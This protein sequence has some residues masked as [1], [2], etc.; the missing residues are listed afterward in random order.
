M[1]EPA[2]EGGKIVTARKGTARFQIHVKGQPAHSGSRHQDGRSAVRE[3]A[4]QILAIEALTDYYKGITTNVG[5]IRG[6]TRANVVPE[7]AYRRSRHARRL[8][9]PGRRDGRQDPRR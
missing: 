5:L 4:R 9:G 3:L 7:D 1:T 2:R 6:G 8:P